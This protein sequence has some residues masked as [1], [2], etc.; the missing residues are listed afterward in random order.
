MS[1]LLAAYLIGMGVRVVFIHG[2][3]TSGKAPAGLNVDIQL[4]ATIFWPFFMLF[5]MWQEIRK[6]WGR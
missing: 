6:A 4:F 5:N 2:L 3:F 1:I